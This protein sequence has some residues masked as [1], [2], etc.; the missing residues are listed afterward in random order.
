MERLKFFDSVLCWQTCSRQD[1]NFGYENVLCTC[2][3][4]I[5]TII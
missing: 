2:M 5:L 4:A 1:E 3:L